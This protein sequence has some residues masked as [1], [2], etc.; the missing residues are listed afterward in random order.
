MIEWDAPP[1]C[2]P[3]ARAVG[4]PTQ[5]P[6][7]R[8][9]AAVPLMSGADRIEGCL[10]ATA[11]QP[12]T[13]RPRQQIALNLYT[14]GSAPGLDSRTRRCAATASSTATS[15][16]PR[17]TP[18]DRDLLHS[19]SGSHQ[20]RSRKHF[21]LH[22][23]NA[24]SGTCLPADRPKDLVR[25]YD[26]V[27]RVTARRARVSIT[28][29]LETEYRAEL[30]RRLQI[31]FKSSGQAVMDDAGKELTRHIFDLRTRIR[32]RRREPVQVSHR[33]LPIAA[34]AAS[35]SQST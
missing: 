10:F 4:A 18:M 12:A 15:P 1:I 26:A 35:S 7:H 27:I 28:Y 20:T 3:H 34:M 11:A 23:A 32:G 29:L 9:A 21:L 24:N 17:D 2:A 31:E 19:F 5:R 22:D 16:V 25:S 30:P 14:Q 33:T 8:H 6:R 13:C